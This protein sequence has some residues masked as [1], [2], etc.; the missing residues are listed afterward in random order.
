MEPLYSGL[1]TAFSVAR[2]YGL[3]RKQKDFVLFVVFLSKE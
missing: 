3:F 2:D 1:L